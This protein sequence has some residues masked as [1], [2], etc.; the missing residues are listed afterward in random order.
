MVPSLLDVPA[1]VGASLPRLC[2]PAGAVKT[3]VVLERRDAVYAVLIGDVRQTCE[4][5]AG[6]E[7]FGRTGC[8]R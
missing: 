8:N 1:G 2:L 3:F 5:P 4:G 7:I 6:D